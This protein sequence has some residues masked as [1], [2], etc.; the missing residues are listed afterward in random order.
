M[1]SGQSALTVAV[2]AKQGDIGNLLQRYGAMIP[3]M[4]HKPG[5]PTYPSGTKVE[6]RGLQHATSLNGR[7]GVVKSFNPDTHRYAVLLGGSETKAI[8]PENLSTAFKDDLHEPIDVTSCTDKVEVKER[9][10]RCRPVTGLRSYKK[11]LGEL[12]SDHLQMPLV[13]ET[14]PCYTVECIDEDRGIFLSYVAM[15]DI[16]AHS[17]QNFRGVM[18][19]TALYGAN[20]EE[21][22]MQSAAKEAFYA[23]KRMRSVEQ[24]NSDSDGDTDVSSISPELVA[25]THASHN[26]DQD[27]E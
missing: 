18:V 26:E 1:P 10:K 11:A 8:K 15:P 7:R 21:A 24:D 17:H 12:V 14:A 27:E 19:N 2:L 20:V 4:P 23:M 9:I 13:P 3:G 16:G 22:A 25:A 6:I 5:A